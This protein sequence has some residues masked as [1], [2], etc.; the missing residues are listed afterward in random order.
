[1]ARPGVRSAEIDYLTTRLLAFPD[2]C[3]EAWRAGQAIAL[4]GHWRRP[5]RVVALGVGG[6]GVGS[7]IAESLVR[8]HGGAA[9]VWRGVGV[10]AVDDDTLVVASSFSGDTAETVEP[11]RA[12]LAGGRGMFLAITRGG[13]LARLAASRDDVVV[14]PITCD[15]PPRFAFPYLVLPVVAVLA[16]LG[17]VDASFDDATVARLRTPA[18][19]L[20]AAGADHTGLRL[21]EAFARA[22]PIVIGS[23]LLRPVARRWQ[24]QLH[25]NAK[26]LAIAAEWPEAA[27]NL[28]EALGDPAHPAYAV[29]LADDDE[30]SRF[31]RRLA[32]V[33]FPVEVLD[34]P[35]DPLERVLLASLIGDW[36]ALHLAELRDAP[37]ARTPV[38]DALRRDRGVA[39]QPGF[40]L[41]ADAAR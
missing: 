36:T 38:I 30:A 19:S 13:E 28:V 11:F 17:V 35:H 18:T 6:S 9:E 8:A 5:R 41:T 33:G 31:G 14:V 23:G 15:G 34:F 2:D 37:I 7:D 21:A 40:G 22:L 1:M 39:P 20:A 26:R 4:P 10:P 29:V 25:E 32:E 3:H 24:A 16:Q 27:H 12:A